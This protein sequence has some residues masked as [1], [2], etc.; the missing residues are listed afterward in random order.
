[1]LECGSFQL[2]HADRHREDPGVKTAD[3]TELNTSSYWLTSQ[4]TF[5][6]IAIDAN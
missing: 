6:R 3:E 1:M 5:V 2:R 4:K